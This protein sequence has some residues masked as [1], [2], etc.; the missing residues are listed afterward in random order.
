MAMAL[1]QRAMHDTLAPATAL[2]PKDLEE[3]YYDSADSR[4]MHNRV[5]GHMT[6]HCFLARVAPA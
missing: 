5:A 6:G 3:F 1:L 4:M 2:R